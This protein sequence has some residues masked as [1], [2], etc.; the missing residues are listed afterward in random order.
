MIGLTSNRLNYVLVINI[1]DLIFE[2]FAIK[3]KDRFGAIENAAVEV[4]TQSASNLE[5]CR[6]M[7]NHMRIFIDLSHNR[8]RA[9]IIS[10]IP[11]LNPRIRA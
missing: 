1:T 9:W 10:A 6:D 11:L 5:M 7:Y 8:T 3:T 2:F 4:G